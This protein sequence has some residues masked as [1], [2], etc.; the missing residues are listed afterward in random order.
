MIWVQ[1]VAEL[2][3]YPVSPLLQLLNK[4]FLTRFGWSHGLRAGPSPAHGVWTDT[5]SVSSAAP[6]S[7]LVT[8]RTLQKFGVLFLTELDVAV[9]EETHEPRWEVNQRHIRGTSGTTLQNKI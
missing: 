5:F 6:G 9:D 3:R 1:Q 7:R 8:A 4:C 2:L